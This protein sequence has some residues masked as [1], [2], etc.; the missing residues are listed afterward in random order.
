MGLL[1]A[2]ASFAQTDVDALRYSQL[3]FGGTAR[4]AS[5]AGSMG[6][7]GGDISTL[8][9]NPAGIAVF[10]KT[11]LTI[12]PSVF[13]QKSTMSFNGSSAVDSKLN[14]N[15]GNIGL[16]ATKNFKDTTS[17]WKN[18]NFGF[19]YNRTNTF[20]AR[21]NAQGYNTQSSLLD[22]F[23]N[24]A[25]G[26]SPSDFDGFSTGLAWQD[27]LINP[28]DSS[29]HYYHVIPNYGEYQQ[30]S[31]ETKGSM[32]ETDFSFGA[33]Y[34]NRVLIGA[35][36]GY[37]NARYVENSVYSETDTK[38][39]IPYFKSFTYTQ[40]LTSK[41]KGVNFK[42]GVIVKATDWLRL[43]AAVHTPTYIS[44]HDDYNSRMQSDLEDGYVYDTTSPDGSFDYRIITPFR[45]MGSVGFVINRIAVI[46]A[47]YEYVDYAAAQI[48]SS[49]EYFN[50]VN[51]T[52]STKY[53]P[54]GNF[55]VGG[56]V[57]F[58][59]FAFRLGYALYGSPYSGGI[60]AN[61]NRSSYTAGIGFRQN[62]FF[63]D[64]AYVL[65]MYK[66][67]SYFYDPSIAY[68]NPVQNNYKGSSFMLTFG[69]RF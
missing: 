34:D 8:A 7:L 14:F 19:A 28:A 15:L 69:V 18:I 26:H 29:N 46:N 62:N 65:T 56:E 5:M 51:N 24:D 58:D 20:Q 57:R 40:N 32:G 31:V 16:V 38:D 6:A 17:G 53:K 4:F 23:V 66:E 43:G 61:A 55:R 39:T 64:F 42:I 68:S 25:N 54:A 37:V 33:N 10:K 2:S 47:E 50:D 22:V 49:P 35:T 63:M 27:Y 44:F 67:Y 13:A 12:T 3:T 52:I 45:A 11:E 41:G 48:H 60:N 30:K 36:I 59:P 21:S 1:C 9:F